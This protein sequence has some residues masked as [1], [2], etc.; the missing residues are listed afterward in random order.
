MHWTQGTQF[1]FSCVVALL[2]VQQ[3][4]VERCPVRVAAACLEASAYEEAVWPLFLCLVGQTH[5]DPERKAHLEPCRLE[6][7]GHVSPFAEALP[8][9]PGC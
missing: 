7:K 8:V 6:V 1:A 5:W 9:S 2:S 3:T 4:Q